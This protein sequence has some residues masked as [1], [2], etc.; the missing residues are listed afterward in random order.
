M[1]KLKHT[2][3]LIPGEIQSSPL[4]FLFFPPM[5]KVSYLKMSLTSVLQIGTGLI[6]TTMQPDTDTQRSLQGWKDM[7]LEVVS[8][9]VFPR[10]KFSCRGKKEII[11]H[12]NMSIEKLDKTCIFSGVLITITTYI[13]LMALI[14]F[15]WLFYEELEAKPISPT[16]SRRN[17]PAVCACPSPGRQEQL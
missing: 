13:P 3:E 12:K 8:K 4:L 1:R 2:N 7:G 10:G 5:M 14:P 16:A 15:K 17:I 11:L 9:L 6:K